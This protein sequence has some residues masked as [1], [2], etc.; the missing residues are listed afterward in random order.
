MTVTASGMEGSIQ[1]TQTGALK[2][3]GRALPDWVRTRMSP[4]RGVVSG[5][6]CTVMVS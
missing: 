1:F 3:S 2:P 6:A 4:W 5:A